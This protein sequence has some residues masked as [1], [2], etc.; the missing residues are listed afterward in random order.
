M[1]WKRVIYAKDRV[2]EFALIESGMVVYDRGKD[3]ETGK[4]VVQPSKQPGR[5]CHYEGEDRSIDRRPAG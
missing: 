5:S 4:F 3:Y 1:T 2:E